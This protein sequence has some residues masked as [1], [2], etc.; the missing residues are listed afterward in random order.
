MENQEIEVWKYIPNFEEYYKISNFG[1][2]LSTGKLFYN[3]VKKYYFSRKIKKMTIHKH[4]AGY[5]SVSLTKNKKTKLYLLHRLL[6]ITFIPN[7]ENKPQVN[8]INGIRS[9][10]RLENLE[11]VTPQEN[12]DN[13]LNRGIKIGR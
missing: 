8:H 12:T 2:V 13:M 9:D 5:F 7:P 6:A 10:Y 4:N 1:N 11:W 3:D